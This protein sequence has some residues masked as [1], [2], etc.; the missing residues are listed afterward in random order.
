MKKILVVLMAFLFLNGCDSGTMTEK[1]D[2]FQY[3][4]SYV[5]DNG[6]VGNITRE[7][8]MPNGEQMNGLELKTTDEPYGIIINY[9]EAD[10]SEYEVTNYNELA[11]YNASII[12]SLVKNA[13]WVQFN[14]LE[15][16]MTV[17]REELENWYGKDLRD[18]A[19]EDELSAFIQ[20][21]LQDEEQVNA[22]FE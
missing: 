14:F 7:L 10:I 8:P 19:S 15:K 20:E 21:Y 1:E 6:A 17:T 2:L 5:G 22:F 18:F 13:D 12:L 4:D 11:L 3:K 9:E 16:E